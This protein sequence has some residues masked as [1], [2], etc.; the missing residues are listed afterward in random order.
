MWHSIFS[1]RI[2]KD[3][4]A[5]FSRHM[6]DEIRNI[7]RR[8]NATNRVSPS[9]PITVCKWDSRDHT[10]TR[11]HEVRNIKEGSA[12]EIVLGQTDDASSS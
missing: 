11:S 2:S 4:F 6:T 3:I 1:E 7:L 5:S 9:P 12:V 8:N 10:Q